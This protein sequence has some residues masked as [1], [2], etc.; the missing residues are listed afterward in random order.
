MIGFPRVSP[1]RLQFSGSPS[2]R[3]DGVEVTSV[4]TV[5]QGGDLSS[6]DRWTEDMEHR[7]QQAHV[8]TL[9]IK[10]DN[11][12][13]EQWFVE[14]YG[15]MQPLK[16][17]DYRELLLKEIELKKKLKDSHTITGKL[18]QWATVGGATLGGVADVVVHLPSL[19]IS[20]VMVPPGTFTALGAAVGKVLKG[21]SPD[22]IEYELHE[23]QSEREEVGTYISNLNRGRR[24]IAEH[25][26]QEAETASV[27]AKSLSPKPRHRRRKQQ[28]DVTG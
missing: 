9:G 7:L 13:E 26:R 12:Q 23:I 16:Q 15:K 19:G 24:E 14:L 17:H 3:N 10:K 8:D 4:P 5:Q 27:K 6:K 18:A 1:G 21:K 2:S 25:H 20:L 28:F 22:K 11:P